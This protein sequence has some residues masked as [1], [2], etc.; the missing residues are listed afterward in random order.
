MGVVAYSP[1]AQGLLSRKYL[2]GIP[3]DSRAARSWSAPKRQEIVDAVRERVRGLHELAQSRGQTLPQMALAWT[4][5][6]SGT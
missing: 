2:D 6:P 4:L 3:E 1:I 5:A